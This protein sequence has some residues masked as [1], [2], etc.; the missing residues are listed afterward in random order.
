MNGA[1]WVA[2]AQSDG[3]TFLFGT[4]GTQAQN[5][6]RHKKPAYDQT[7]D[8]TS[9]GLF[10]EAPL[11]LVVRK[12]LPVGSR[13][14]FVAYAKANADKMQFGSAGTGSAI[15]SAAR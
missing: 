15:I 6:T 12:D 14:E 7:R 10:L 11:V 8:F 4:V 3:S 2:K 5:Q 13:K 9:V 1:D